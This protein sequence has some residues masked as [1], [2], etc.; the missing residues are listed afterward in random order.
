MSQIKIENLTFGYEGSAD[1]VFENVS[2]EL[3]T[4]W[5][6]GFTG[7]NGKGKTTFLNLLMGKYE[8]RGTIS[9]GVE[10]DYFPYEVPDPSR[11]T[12]EVLRSVCPD[13]EDWQIRR[14][15]SLLGVREETQERPFVT[16]SRGEQTKI[17]L[18]ALFL[19]ENSF[20]LIDEPTNHLDLTGRE[21][22]GQYLNRKKGFI[23]VSHDRAFLDSCV[24]HIL[25]INRANIEIQRGNFSSWQENKQ[26]RDEFEFA[27]NEKLQKEASRLKAAAKKA[28]DRADHLEN[29]KI[30]FNPAITEKS[31]SR[32]PLMAAKSK[33]VMQRAKSIEARRQAELEEKS[34][35]LRNV[36]SAEELKIHPLPYP[37]PVLAE[38]VNLEIRYGDRTIC[39][40][41]S[42]RI[43][44]G[45]RL[46]LRGANGAGKS[47]ILKLLQGEEVPH[48]GT[49][50]RG[51]SL[52]LSCVPQDCSGLS[53]GLRE[54]EREQNLDGSLFR[55]ILR[56]LDFSREQ[57]EKDLS[58]YSEGQK[59]KVLLAASLCR[60]AHLYVWDEPLNYVDV[61]SRMQLETLIRE[62]QPTMVL[63]EHDR[64]FQEDVATQIIDL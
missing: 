56:K 31:I 21:L 18:A 27:E 15:F 2:F 3:D 11:K 42:F 39:G 23:L 53:G 63:V 5:K 10:F 64:A 57:F 14:E 16:L 58:G 1:N 22:V 13:A 28:A 54:F 9:S 25:S 59:K 32:R 52:V 61:L 20:L 33:K 41:V 26:R 36:D 24:D 46:L 37:K 6:L 45:D 7:R 38:A 17:L 35:L 55:A 40:P 29:G 19:R 34:K 47:S 51:G 8:Y 43:K 12:E 60:P 44:S 4:D 49:L 48:S 30:G 62:F 50:N